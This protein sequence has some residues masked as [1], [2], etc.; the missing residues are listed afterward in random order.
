M[1][2]EQPYEDSASDDAGADPK[3]A[4]YLDNILSSGQSLLEMINELLDMAKI[5]A[6]FPGMATQVPPGSPSCTTA[7]LPGM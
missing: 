3:R 6:G 4:R 7:A 2:Q 1:R 5:E